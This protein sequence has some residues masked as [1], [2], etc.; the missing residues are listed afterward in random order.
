MAMTDLAA[1]SPIVLINVFK[2]EAARQDELIEHLTALN[3]VQRG[4]PGFISATLH[5]GVNGRTV[6]NYVVWAAAADWK[7]MTRHPDVVE[8][9]RPVMAL[10]TFEPHLYAPGEVIS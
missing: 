9:M 10:A 3:Q 6:A 4:L 8:G 7:A 5:R 1:I 2:C